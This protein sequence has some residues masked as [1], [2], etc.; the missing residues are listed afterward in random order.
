MP[1]LSPVC[2]GVS[3]KPLPGSKG[4]FGARERRG[5]P[6]QADLLIA[7]LR[8]A[9]AHAR[10]LE[11]PEIMRAGIAQHG[12]RFNEL[13]ARGF[14]IENDTTREAGAVRSQYW[15]RH[16]PEQDGHAE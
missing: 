8:E 2:S 1:P 11:L 4:M 16:D 6:T 15:L 13:R 5:R 7:M 10:P 12:A 9:R 14:V 3:T